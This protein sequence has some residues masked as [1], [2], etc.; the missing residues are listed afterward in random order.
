[1]SARW[2]YLRCA[3]AI[4]LV[5]VTTLA[6]ADPLAPFRVNPGELAWVPAPNGVVRAYVAGDDKKAGVY[7]YFARIPAHFK[8]QPHWHPDERVVTVISGTMYVGYGE[9][10]DEA[11]MKE[12][13]KGSAWTEPARHAHYTWARDGEVVIY[14]VGTGPSGTTPAGQ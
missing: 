5:A 11:T 8:F 6:T 13:P 12:L 7:A 10:W 4:G 9:R 3:M 2:R 14:V 1:M